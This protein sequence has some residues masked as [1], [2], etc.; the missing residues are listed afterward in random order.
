MATTISIHQGELL[1]I[2]RTITAKD[3]HKSKLNCKGA[4]YGLHTMSG[5][6]V[7]QMICAGSKRD[8]QRCQEHLRKKHGL[9]KLGNWIVSSHD[10]VSAS[11]DTKGNIILVF[12]IEGQ[13][14]TA[15]D[16]EG[17]GANL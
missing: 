16:T 13:P 12:D 8:L 11:K 10:K 4:L 15:Y 14:C 9:R 3:K 2:Q 17:N 5:Q 1:L 7:V 6:P